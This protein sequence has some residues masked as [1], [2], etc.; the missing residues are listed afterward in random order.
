[1]SDDRKKNPKT[2]FDLA[3]EPTPNAESPKG[4]TLEQALAQ[5]DEYHNGDEEMKEII[6][7]GYNHQREEV[8]PQSQ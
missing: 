4:L 1:M 2:I 7:R 8:K 6:R 5:V 3:D